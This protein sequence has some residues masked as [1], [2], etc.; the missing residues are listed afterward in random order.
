MNQNPFGNPEQ[1]PS[2]LMNTLV[3]SFW[4]AMAIVLISAVKLVSCHFAGVPL[5][6]CGWLPHLGFLLGV[7]TAVSA[8]PFVL[9][10]L[11]DHSPWIWSPDDSRSRNGEPSGDPD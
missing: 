8:M 5:Q 6:A 1:I 3:L 10:D 2:G 7:F 11:F 9:A 4:I